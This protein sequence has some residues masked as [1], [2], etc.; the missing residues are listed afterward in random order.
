LVAEVG[1]HCPGGIHK[2]AIGIYELSLAHGFGNPHSLDALAAQANHLAKF[3]LRDQI[4]CRNSKARR[5]DSIE[6]SRR[7]AALNVPQHAHPNLLLCTY[8]DGI[9]DQ[10]SNRAGPAIFFQFRSGGSVTPSAT[11]VNRFP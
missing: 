4:Y 9:A 8:R 3:P 7:S 10:V 2:L 11:I 6:R 1:N 5:Q